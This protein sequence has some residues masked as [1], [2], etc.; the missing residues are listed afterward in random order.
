MNGEGLSPVS[1]RKIRH[2]GSLVEILL[3]CI[4]ITSLGGSGLFA[5]ER[6][7]VTDYTVTKQSAKSDLA[8]GDLYAVVIGVSKYANPKISALNYADKDASDFAQF[9]K[10]QERLFRRLHVTL[11]LNERATSAQVKKEL[12]YGLKRAGKDDTVVLFLSG[13]GAD[14]PLNPGEFF[15][16]TH[17]GDPDCLEA[18][19]VNLTEMKFMKRLDTKRAVLI[20]DTC[21]AGG[22]S[23]HGVKGVEASFRRLMNQFRESEGKV[24]LT[25]CR[26]DELSMEKRG[27]ANSVF[28]H[29]LLQALRGNADSNGDGIVSLQ[30]VYGYVYEKAKDETGGAQHPQLDGRMIGLFPLSLAKPLIGTASPP[31]I[32]A[33][34]QSESMHRNE[35][36]ALMESAEKG[37]IEAQFLLGMIYQKGRLGLPRNKIEALRW[38]EKAS[39]GGHTEARAILA[40]I[41]GSGSTPVTTVPYTS[42]AV[43]P[44]PASLNSADSYIKNLW[45]RANQGERQAQYTLAYKLEH[46]QGVQRNREEAIRWYKEAAVRG[47]SDA[48]SALRRLGVR[49]SDPPFNIHGGPGSGRPNGVDSG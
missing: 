45:R 22:F 10:S 21:H 39:R 11:L 38:L 31:S 19:G 8:T 14:D 36:S 18:T 15:F 35:L 34:S 27:L 48:V 44:V 23:M 16:I 4:L 49:V 12:V 46:G 28:T 3:A 43:T 32:Q 47:D 30:E 33:P 26:P 25:S 41:Q 24:I 42:P 7:G 6:K 1:R 5:Q 17:D 40:N 37:D 13:H 2:L 9:L 20:A 29:Y